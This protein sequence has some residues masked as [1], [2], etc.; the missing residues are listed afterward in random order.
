MGEVAARQLFHLPAQ[1]FLTGREV[2]PETLRYAELGN[3]VSSMV[4]QNPESAAQLL[5]RWVEED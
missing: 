3:E 4:K 2:D 5:R 1:S